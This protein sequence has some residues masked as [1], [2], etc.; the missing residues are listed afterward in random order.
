MID[1]QY[2]K[3]ITHTPMDDGSDLIETIYKH[4][5]VVKQSIIEVEMS[6]L[7]KDKSEVMGILLDAIELIGNAKSHHVSIEMIADPF[8]Y[9][10]KRIVIRYTIKNKPVL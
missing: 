6:R 2:G 3:I 5:S 1:L 4:D 9:Q 8:T 10:Y 7:V